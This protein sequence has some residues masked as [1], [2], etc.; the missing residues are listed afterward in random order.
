MR[1]K[2]P[3]SEGTFNKI[4]F[5]YNFYNILDVVYFKVCVVVCYLY[6]I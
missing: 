5:F 4:E 3:R 1:W 2:S 6:K